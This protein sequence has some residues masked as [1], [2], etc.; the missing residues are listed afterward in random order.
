MTVELTPEDV[1][2]FESFYH[3][4]LEQAGVATDAEELAFAQELLQAARDGL[5]PDEEGNI[6]HID[7]EAEVEWDRPEAIDAAR[8]V[9][10]R[11]LWFGLKEA[12]IGAGI[13][14]LAVVLLW[15]G[16]GGKED[17]ETPTAEAALGMEM[18]T[19][20]PT[21]VGERAMEEVV[22]SADVRVPMVA[23]RTL[24]VKGA[25]FI[26]W[27]T[28]VKEGDW[29]RPDEENAA[30]WV[31]GTVVNYVVG[32]KDTPE[33]EKV[34]AS[35]GADDEIVLRKSTGAVILFVYD[36]TV[37]VA[38]Q[39]SEIFR[40]EEPGITIVLL[41]AEGAERV[42]VRGRYLANQEVAVS[43]STPPVNSGVSMSTSDVTGEVP[44]PAT[45]TVIGGNLMLTATIAPPTATATPVPPTATPTDTSS[46][47]ATSTNTP[48]P[49]PT[50]TNTPIPTWTPTN[51]PTSTRTSTPTLTPTPTNTPIV[52]FHVVEAGDTL[53]SIA[54]KYGTTVEVLKEING[55]TSDKIKVG[56][57]IFLPAP[58]DA[59][60][61][62][63]AKGRGVSVSASSVS[64]AT[65][66]PTAIVTPTP[67]YTPTPTTLPPL[68]TI[69][70]QL[71]EERGI[72]EIV[73]IIISRGGT[74][75]LA[76][77]DVVV[78]NQ[79]TGNMVFPVK[80]SADWPWM[81]EAGE[82]VE[83]T[84]SYPY[85]D[86]GLRIKVAGMEF[87]VGPLEKE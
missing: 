25:T 33:N 75:S 21:P 3:E 23:P 64:T 4:R 10:K 52:Q 1:K 8:G 71:W 85:P 72:A 57:R 80:L 47:T 81:V 13:L 14:L 15:P 31:F 41:G 26:I 69:S 83:F 37:K 42:V 66:T 77:T 5:T 39:A 48:T 67:T 60:P 29:P 84:A 62:P 74:V 11:R 35:L 20:T 12:A 70:A 51:T 63:E 73:Y 53:S 45:P 55:L 16:G 54:R 28:E 56:Q 59:T 76:S 6:Y 44:T 79:G 43:V 22:S 61:A 86:E 36:G 82:T 38:P 18:P 65:A 32:L 58:A 40:Q 7:P 9:G 30:S 87:T 34:L 78:S 68:V 2:G 24:E 46:P 17:K 49:T 27:P 50:A 19:N